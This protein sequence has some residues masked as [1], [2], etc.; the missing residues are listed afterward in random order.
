MPRP[1]PREAPATRAT[2]A[3]S[4]MTLSRLTWQ[5]VAAGV[6]INDHSFINKSQDAATENPARRESAR[7]GSPAHPQGRARG[8][9]LCAPGALLRPGAGDPG[10]ALQDQGRSHAGDPASCLGWP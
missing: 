6:Y 7:S 1:A 9:D 8:A 5:T 4:C 3:L 10:A 2:F